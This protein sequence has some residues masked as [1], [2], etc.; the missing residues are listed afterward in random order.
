MIYR[1]LI[2]LLLFSACQRKTVVVQD[3]VI[4]VDIDTTLNLL[5]SDELPG[6]A[7]KDIHHLLE[8]GFKKVNKA[9]DSL[10]FQMYY[11]SELKD[12]IRIQTAGKD[13]VFLTIGNDQNKKVALYSYLDI[14]GYRFYGPEDHWTYIPEI[15][16]PPPMDTIVHSVFGLRR[17]AASYSV[18][19]PYIV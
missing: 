1:M 16:S 7:L 15:H 4:E 13:T 9:Y 11:D 3:K 10:R 17:F 14:L 19:P 5:A 8:I 6:N 18:G 2:I 12:S